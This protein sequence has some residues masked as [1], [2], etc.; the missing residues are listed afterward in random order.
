MSWPS[1]VSPPA[2]PEASVRVCLLG[3]TGRALKYAKSEKATGSRKGFFVSVYVSVLVSVSV[4]VSLSVSISLRLHSLLFFV[5]VGVG[6]AFALALFVGFSCCFFHSPSRLSDFQVM[7][8]FLLFFR[9]LPS[10]P[11]RWTVLLMDCCQVKVMSYVGGFLLV[12]VC[13]CL[14]WDSGLGQALF[15]LQ[16]LLSKSPRLRAAHTKRAM[17]SSLLA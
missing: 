2:R 7:S 17:K 1:R 12:C 6:V 4:S 8:F 13:L 16:G 11:L 9:L 5:V 3:L 15:I 10:P 14:C